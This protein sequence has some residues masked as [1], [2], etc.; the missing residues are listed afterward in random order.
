MPETFS[1][2]IWR[3]DQTPAINE[4]N[5]NRLEVGVDAIDARAAALERGITAPVT[6]PYATSITL[7][8]TQGALFRCT[9]TGDL[10][11]DDI[12]GGTNGQAIV[13]EVVASGTSR[14]LHFTGSTDSIDVAAGQRWIG[15]FR[16]DSGANTW[17]LT[18]GSGGGSSSSGNSLNIL[19][20]QTIAWAA[21]ITPNAALGA[22]FRIVAIGDFT[23]N[24]PINGIN[25]QTV[26]VEVTASG[27]SRLLS[28]AGGLSSVVIPSGGRWAGA[29]RYDS[30]GD[31]WGLDDR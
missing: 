19:A 26:I 20:P 31:V 15:T 5:L 17:T 28:F 30:S 2:I 12:V 25:G 27:G 1:P 21:T 13:L 29:F 4:N 16:H 8:A 18:D 23:L 10:T 6:V 11:L 22:L 9:A 14:T 3:N 24:A 7:N